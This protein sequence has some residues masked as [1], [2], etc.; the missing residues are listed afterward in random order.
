MLGSTR[1]KSADPSLRIKLLKNDSYTTTPFNLGYETASKS[2]K[3]VN[4]C[5]LFL[6]PKANPES[7]KLSAF[8]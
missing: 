2:S 5:S 4:K 6:I 8:P 3:T 1:I 7:S